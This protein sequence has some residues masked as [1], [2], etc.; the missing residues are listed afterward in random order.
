MAYD[1][2]AQNYW[3][4]L[5]PDDPSYDSRPW[6]SL[7]DSTHPFT[8]W[9]GVSGVY[10]KGLFWRG[11]SGVWEPGFNTSLVGVTPGALSDASHCNASP[12]TTH[13]PTYGAQVTFTFSGPGTCLSVQ[14]QWYID[15]VAY[16]S[17]QTITTGIGDRTSFTTGS[18]STPSTAG[19]GVDDGSPHVWSI[20][21]RAQKLD[22]T[23]TSWTTPGS[24]WTTNYQA[25]GRPV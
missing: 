24:T 8:I 25:C 22:G 5:A 19:T 15:G 1:F 14:V 2:Y 12:A 20:Q 7:D 11:R 9:K 21:W 10:T 3:N 4:T 16:L 18:Q 13:P 23:Y 17:P 6:L